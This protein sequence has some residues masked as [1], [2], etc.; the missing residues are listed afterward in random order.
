LQ[1]HKVWLSILFGLGVLLP[2]FFFTPVVALKD[3]PDQIYS[4]KTKHPTAYIRKTDTPTPKSTQTPTQVDTLDT[5]EAQMQLT[6]DAEGTMHAL[7]QEELTKNPT[8]F[9]VAAVDKKRTP[10]GLCGKS[11]IVVPVG[12]VVLALF[13]RRSKNTYL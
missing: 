5:Y 1:K 3:N 2:V 7:V 8:M 9:A 6:F 10:N 4:K 11:F 13:K 12:L